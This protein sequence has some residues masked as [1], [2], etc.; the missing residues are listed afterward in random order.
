MNLWNWYKYI[1]V[2]VLVFSLAGCSNV[3][4]LKKG[5][6]ITKNQGYT[7][8]VHEY[9]KAAE[10]G[11][12]DAQS[13]L[14]MSYFT[15]KGVPKKDEAE[16]V[17]WFRKAAKQGNPDA[18]TNLGMS[19]F[20]GKGL[21]K[22]DEVEAVRWF[23]KAAEQGDARAQFILGFSYSRGM[24]VQ[25][26]T[27]K[28]VSWYRKAAEQ[29]EAKAQFFL[30]VSYFQGKGVQQDTEKATRWYRKA[31][32]QGDLQAQKALSSLEKSQPVAKEEKENNI[33]RYIEALRAGDYETAAAQ[34]MYPV[35]ITDTEKKN[36]LTD[37]MK[38][39]EKINVVLGNI[40]DINSVNMPSGISKN[41]FVSMIPF[42]DHPK[43]FVSITIPV[44]FITAGV[45]V[46]SF[47]M[48]E[49]DGQQGIYEVQY[50][51]FTCA[52]KNQSGKKE[53]YPIS[54]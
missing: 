8:K 45:G 42:K 14:G 7:E 53:R 36:K 39:I 2:T 26:N 18:Q 34:L 11:D 41:Y 38:G 44:V 20:T 43:I 21:P 30:G 25:Q 9:R 16:A 29:G 32:K 17:R 12:S 4:S 51:C 3:G 22:K 47:M 28:A 52:V 31:A 1:A 5:K 54:G 35:N 37:A 33:T 40:S 49:I 50:W 48:G 19:Y 27:E 13:H 24:G 23:R 15:G 46:L 10:Q 6:E